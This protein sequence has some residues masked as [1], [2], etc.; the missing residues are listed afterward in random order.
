MNQESELPNW[1]EHVKPNFS[2][3]PI[4]VPMHVLQLGAYKGDCTDYLLNNHDIQ[5]IVDVD[6][7]EGS[8]EHVNMNFNTVEE[9]YDKKFNCDQIDGYYEIYS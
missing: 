1:F 7:W 3:L 9:I 5:K 6:T 8:M 4:D 2:L